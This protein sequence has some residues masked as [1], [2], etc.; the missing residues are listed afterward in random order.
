MN[1]PLVEVIR[2]SFINKFESKPI[3][4]FSPGRINIIGEHT[5][6]NDGYCS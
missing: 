5:D 1:K 6:Y 4:I 2:S 3:L